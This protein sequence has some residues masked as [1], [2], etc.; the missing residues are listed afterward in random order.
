MIRH[1]SFQGFAEVPCGTFVVFQI[2]E[3]SWFGT[4]L[5]RGSFMQYSH[6]EQKVTART[7]ARGRLISLKP[8]MRPGLPLG[9]TL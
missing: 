9:R 5:I 6:T 8:L 7:P 4:E 2:D 3:L 1:P